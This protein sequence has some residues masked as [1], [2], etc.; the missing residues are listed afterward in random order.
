VPGTRYF[1]GQNA[2]AWASRYNLIRITYAR[3]GC[4]EN[5]HVHGYCGSRRDIVVAKGEYHWWSEIFMLA[6]NTSLDL[7]NFS[8]LEHRDERWSHS[9]QHDVLNLRIFV[10]IRY[11]N[12]EIH[13]KTASARLAQSVERETLS[14]H[15]L[16]RL[17]WL[18]QGCGFDPHVGLS[19]C[20]RLVL[21]WKGGVDG[22]GGE[23]YFLPPHLGRLS[24]IT[25]TT[26]SNGVIRCSL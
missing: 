21:S 17:D 15:V 19:F 20:S 7:P 16:I 10:F 5:C 8:S 24:S 25:T 2:C 6:K 9:H 14:F 13:I 12:S 22:G 3:I 4:L 23:G 18:S 1:F 26:T 11:L